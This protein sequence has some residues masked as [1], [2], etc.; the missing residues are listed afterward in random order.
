MRSNL[1]CLSPCSTG[2]QTCK[3]F[4]KQ[5]QVTVQSSLYARSYR[6]PNFPV[7][8]TDCNVHRCFFSPHVLHELSLELR[9]YIL[10]FPMCIRVCLPSCMLILHCCFLFFRESFSWGFSCSKAYI[11][12]FGWFTRNDS[13]Q[14]TNLW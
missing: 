8:D 13:W 12:R 11:S 3:D 14:W 2:G 1:L 10:R 5:D 7:A 9:K 6:R 4:C